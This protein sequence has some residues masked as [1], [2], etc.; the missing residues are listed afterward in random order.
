MNDKIKFHEKQILILE[1]IDRCT[2]YILSCE[3]DFNSYHDFMNMQ[4]H[5]QKRIE[6][7]KAVKQKLINYYNSRNGKSI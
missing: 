5:Y 1:N 6:I 3:S 7:T 4:K 2:N